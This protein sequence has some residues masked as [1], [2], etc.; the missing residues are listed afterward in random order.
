MRRNVARRARRLL[1]QPAQPLA[2]HHPSA[3]F[4]ESRRLD[5]RGAW[6]GEWGSRTRSISGKLANNFTRPTTVTIDDGDG[7]GLEL[8]GAATLFFAKS[9]STSLG[10]AA[11]IRASEKVANRATLSVQTGF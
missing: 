8:G 5:L 4:G 3:V 9:W 7:R 11:D 10:Y 6:H 2:P 1:R